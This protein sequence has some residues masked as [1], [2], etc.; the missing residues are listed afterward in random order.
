MRVPHALAAEWQRV[1][2]ELAKA[3]KAGNE[4]AAIEPLRHP[5]RRYGAQSPA[6]PSFHGTIGMAEAAFNRVVIYSIGA[7]GYLEL[8]RAKGLFMHDALW[9]GVSVKLENAAFH[10]DKMGQSLEPP[11]RTAMNAALQAAGTIIDTRWQRSFYA[12]LDAFLSAT[13]SVAEV[14]KACFGVDDHREMR[15]WFTGLHPDEQRRRRDFRRRFQKHYEAF[16]KLS[17]GKARHVSEHR[18][19]YPPVTATVNGMFGVTYVGSPTKAVPISETRQVADP[20]LAA[21]VKPR[22]VHPSWR[23]FDIGGLGLFQACDDYLKGAQAL[24]NEARSIAQMVHGKE[25]PHPASLIKQ[26]EQE[27]GM[28]GAA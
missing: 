20:A 16:C 28:A 22:P 13:R 21:L 9:A 5:A 18:A 11:E 4:P 1:E 26:V 23:D 2:V 12:H 19:G 25:S 10:F 6:A 15:A 7:A 27:I 8:Y 14:I 3:R 17:L 24:A